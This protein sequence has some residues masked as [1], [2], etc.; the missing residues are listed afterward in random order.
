[1]KKNNKS[2]NSK[3]SRNQQSN[4]EIFLPLPKDTKQF[5]NYFKNNIN[6]YYEFNYPIITKKNNKIEIKINREIKKYKFKKE[7]IENIS[8][9]IEQRLNILKNNYQ[10]NEFTAEIQNRMVIGLG[11]SHSQETSMTLHH[12]YG[13]PYIPG[14]AIKGVTRHWFILN[15]YY[16]TFSNIN[17]INNFEKILENLNLNND[18][19]IQVKKF[20]KEKDN[21]DINISNIEK[22]KNIIQEYQS[23]FG[24][25]NQKGK[26]IFLDAFPVDNIN[27]KLDI[28]N[29]HYPD[30]YS[31]KEAPTDFQNPIP[32]YFLTLEKTKFK[33]FLLAKE[34][35]NDLL[36]KTKNYLLESLKE[37]GIGA[38]TSLGYGLFDNFIL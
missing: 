32:I 11:S 12:I 23:I 1:M 8:K 22:N 26:I 7:L 34:K 5:F 3:N 18:I 24:T 10:V 35:E 21:I 16:N 28:M 14:S 27:L 20:F 4:S 37:Y 38:K 31:K 9:R 6:F 2:N 36:Q 15:H 13:I 29:V 17:S 30:Y 33:F 19:E 25:Q